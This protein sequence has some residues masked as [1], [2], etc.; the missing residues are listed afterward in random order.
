MHALSSDWQPEFGFSLVT[1]V[2]R[3]RW[4]VSLHDLAAL[5]LKEKYP[6]WTPLKRKEK[7][8]QTR[9]NLRWDER[10][11]ESSGR[12]KWQSFHREGTA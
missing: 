7:A 9:E 2:D 12:L 6:L 4:L 3:D 8:R 10:A 11:A 1:A 5:F